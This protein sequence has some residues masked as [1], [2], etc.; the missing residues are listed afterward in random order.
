MPYLKAERK[1]GLDNGLLPTT[2]GDLTYVFTRA[3]LGDPNEASLT[4]ALEAG[5]DRYFARRQINYGLL[6]DVMGTLTCAGCEYERRSGTLINRPSDADYVRETLTSLR[7]FIQSFY[8]HV[9]APYE[10]TKI[11][12]NGDV[13]PA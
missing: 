1:Q 12:Q 6:C 4:E 9:I 7:Q 3:L 10:D 5:I 8:A 13:Y 2:T 11:E